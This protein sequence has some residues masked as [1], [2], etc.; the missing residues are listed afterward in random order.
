MASV[1]LV[2]NNLTGNKVK[3]ESVSGAYLYCN[4]SGFQVG[5]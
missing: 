4:Y 5:G 1:C 2:T 3:K